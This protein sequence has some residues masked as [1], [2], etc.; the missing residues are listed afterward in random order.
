MKSFENL[1]WVKYLPY[2][3]CEIIHL[4]NCEIFCWRQKVKW[5][6]STHARRHFTLRSNISHAKRISQIPQGIY[7]VEKDLCFV[8]KHRSFS[9]GSGGIRT[10]GTVRYNWFRVLS[11]IWKMQ[12]FDGIY[13]CFLE[14]IFDN[15]IETLFG[16]NKRRKMSC[17][18]VK[19]LEK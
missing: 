4:V 12:I 19:S 2:G 5:N 7:F 17:S 6:K 9:G 14:G 11:I 15:L 18:S 16:E 8:S 3:K 10:H 1:V 13:E